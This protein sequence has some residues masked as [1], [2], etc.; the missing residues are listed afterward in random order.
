MSDVEATD[1]EL[2]MFHQTSIAYTSLRHKQHIPLRT[3]S[4]TKSQ[5]ATR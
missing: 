2:R 4:F 1:L 5:S 3:M